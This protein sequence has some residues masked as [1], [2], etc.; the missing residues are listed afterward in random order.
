MQILLY[1]KMKMRTTDEA[2]NYN[3]K[4]KEN[5][6]MEEGTELNMEKEIKK[7]TAEGTELN[8]EKKENS[9]A[10]VGEMEEEARWATQELNCNALSALPARI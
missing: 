10:G 2:T 5:V 9:D 6:D 4:Q 7:H 8:M 1:S 3:M